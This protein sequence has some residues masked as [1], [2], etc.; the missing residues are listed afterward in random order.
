MPVGTIQLGRWIDLST[1]LVDCGDKFARLAL[2]LA[3]REIRRDLVRQ[4]KLVA[5]CYDKKH[6]QAREESPVLEK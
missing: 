3:L 2:H 1:V 5:K 4:E 6:G